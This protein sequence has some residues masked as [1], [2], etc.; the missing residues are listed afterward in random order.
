[1]PS[2]VANTIVTLVLGGALAATHAGCELRDV[3]RGPPPFTVRS[4]DDMLV[5]RLSAA[6]AAVRRGG[7][8][9]PGFE[10]TVVKAVLIYDARG[11]WFFG[12]SRD[13]RGFYR[14]GQILNGAPVTYAE[15]SLYL[16][17]E[18]KP[19]ARIRRMDGWLGRIGWRD[20][21][22]DAPYRRSEPMLILQELGIAKQN[23]PGIADTERWIGVYVHESFH[24]FQHSFSDVRRA[25]RIED[26]QERD[27]REV[28]E[29]F[30]EI[31]EFRVAV[32]A[33]LG[34]RVVDG[35]VDRD[36]IVVGRADGKFRAIEVRVKDSSLEM[37]DIVVTF[38]DGSTFSPATRLVFGENSRSRVI[39]LPGNR[40]A[41]RKVEFRYGNLPG[42][43][44]ADIELWGRE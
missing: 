32:Q 10:N 34:G 7:R 40:R 31:G 43:G 39:D 22:P 19:Y 17:T 24:V 30:A 27:D 14:T 12:E 18:V 11:E 5:R 35:K 29:R 8:I 15:P 21:D 23:H 33:E 1:M 13:L 28:L 4:A 2:R 38:G 26:S 44:R 37:F 3:N 25:M 9:W 20:F 6:Q 41:I 36:T 42:G 16:T